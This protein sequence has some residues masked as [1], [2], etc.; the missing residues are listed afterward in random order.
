MT[1]LQIRTALI[2]QTGRNSLV[3]DAAGGDYSDNG[4][5]FHIEE[6]L[7]FLDDAL[8]HPGITR[9]FVQKVHSAQQLLYFP[10]ARSAERVVVVDSDGIEL[11]M[12]RD[13]GFDQARSRE[14][15]GMPTMYTVENFD[16]FL[17]FTAEVLVESTTASGNDTL[18]D[19]EVTPGWG[20]VATSTATSELS[21]VGTLS[22]TV[23]ASATA[24]GTWKLCYGDPGEDTP[25]ITSPFRKITVEFTLE[26]SLAAAVPAFVLRILGNDNMEPEQQTNLV[27]LANG[28]Y[29]YT[30]DAV[31]PNG[32]VYV[33]FRMIGDAAAISNSTATI[34]N[35]RVYT[36]C[37]E[38]IRVWP[39][40][41]ESYTIYAYG[42]YLNRRLLSESDSNWWTS[43]YPWEV[44]R[45]AKMSIEG[46]LHRNETG[47]DGH[48]R[49]LMLRV[50]QI[51]M[52]RFVAPRYRGKP[53]S[54][55][56]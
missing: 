3:T 21:D 19:G 24:V 2:D 16:G 27:A 17:P 29:S 46:Q 40:P 53:L 45:A 38:S 51:Y 34:S 42:R 37:T 32:F 56:G 30:F 48:L 47:E 15:T 28:R 10:D 13:D 25:F 20:L 44:I 4:A 50:R 43:E 9:Q 11:T 52:N 39:V 35:V 36:H 5:D 41:S 55:M 12:E 6:G 7:S 22:F 8:P 1:K 14:S 23:P 49:P 54:R 31:T 33:S 26:R 18:F